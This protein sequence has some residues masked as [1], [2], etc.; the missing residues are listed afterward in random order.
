MSDELILESPSHE[1]V[2]AAAL[3]TEETGLPEHVNVGCMG[4]AHPYI[5]RLIGMAA[6]HLDMA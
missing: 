1:G 2:I 6:D 5:Q 4:L 3:L